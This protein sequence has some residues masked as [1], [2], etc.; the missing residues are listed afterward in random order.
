MVVKHT[1]N[2]LVTSSTG[3]EVLSSSDVTI[4][5]SRLRTSVFLVGAGL[6]GIGGGAS[7]TAEILFIESEN[8]PSC[9]PKKLLEW[10]VLTTTDEIETMRAFAS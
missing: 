3:S 8:S 1:L 2:S 9:V 10:S 5:S 4:P 6:C 7:Q